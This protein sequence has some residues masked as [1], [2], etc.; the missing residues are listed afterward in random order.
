[1]EIGTKLRARANLERTAADLAEAIAV[2]AQEYLPLVKSYPAIEATNPRASPA[3]IP[4]YPP[5]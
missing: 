1:L 5:F 2:F 4:L 3:K